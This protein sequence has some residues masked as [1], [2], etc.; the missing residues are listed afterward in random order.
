M[1]GV[2][3]ATSKLGDYTLPQKR[4]TG[5][6]GD[7]EAKRTVLPRLNELL[8]RTPP[9]LPCGDGR[10]M[11][12]YQQISAAGC[13]ESI[14]SNGHVAH[15]NTFNGSHSWLQAH[16]S[17]AGSNASSVRIE[18]IRILATLTHR[19]KRRHCQGSSGADNSEPSHQSSAMGGGKTH[20]LSHQGPGHPAVFLIDHSSHGGP[21]G[22]CSPKCGPCLAAILENNARG[23]SSSNGPPRVT[24]TILFDRAPAI[25]AGPSWSVRDASHPGQMREDSDGSST[26]E[27]YSAINP[28]KNALS[29]N[30]SRRTFSSDLTGSNADDSRTPLRQPVAQDKGA[31]MRE[32]YATPP[33]KEPLKF[34][35]V[36]KR[37]LGLKRA[38]R[39]TALL[40]KAHVEFAENILEQLKANE[41]WKRP[42]RRG[43][44]SS[45]KKRFED[46]LVSAGSSRP[47][48]KMQLVIHLFI[49]GW[50]WSLIGYACDKV[51]D[52]KFSYRS[53]SA[54]FHGLRKKNP[55]LNEAVYGKDCHLT[56]A[57]PWA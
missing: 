29:C 27:R 11:L 52:D 34:I 39:S 14:T 12:C 42:K 36:S 8:E 35:I 2:E 3:S 20:V 5:V 24:G 30:A 7:E 50:R 9:H 46:Y 44:V 45:S 19:Q 32:K 18:N 22:L 49:G 37:I 4:S 47:S 53:L 48:T 40:E 41:D 28:H 43:D 33:C 26:I 55:A 31:M 38:Y 56:I 17:S 54:R 16:S 15:A 1:L 23:K 13:R 51:F 57:T 25:S 6:T 21:P 10:C